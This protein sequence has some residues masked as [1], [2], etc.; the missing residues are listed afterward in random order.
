M[1]NTVKRGRGRPRKDSKDAAPV[2]VS[3]AGY[4]NVFLGMGNNKDRGSYTKFSTSRILSYPELD[5]MYVSEG[6]ARKVIDLPAEEMMRCGFEVE[7]ADDDESL[8]ALLEDIKAMPSVTDALKWSSLY[9]GALIVALLNDG[10]ELQDPLREESIKGIESL[11]VY[12]RWQ[13]S[14][15]QKYNDPADKRF[16]QTQ[17]WQISPASGMPYMVHE[18]RCIVVDGAQVPD[19]VREQNDGWGASRL[20]HCYDQLVRAGSS[21]Y[22]ANALLERSQ[23]AVHG[24]NGLTNILRSPGGENL[25]RQRVDI[26]DLSRSVSNTIVIDGEG[27]TYDVL[28]AT[29]TGV[30]DII[31]RL[32]HALCAVSGIPEQLLFGRQQS[33]IGNSGQ[34]SLESWYARIGQM[35]QNTLLPIIDRLITWAMYAQGRYTQDYLIE[36]KPLWVPSEKENAEVA[37]RK[38]K[39]AEMYVNM[40]A[41]D[42][43]EVRKGL[44]DQ[45]EI[46]DVD[47]L[48]EGAED[49]EGDDMEQEDNGGAVV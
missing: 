16:G 20:Q 12:D 18:S 21:H 14:R 44:E 19:R 6:F 37:E 7:G 31:D 22:W 40:G 27:E 11:R 3:D 45:Y 32:Q 39:T 10:G 42:P 35:Q 46:D 43:S 2:M 13:V 28:T 26:V 8:M 36:F 15:A 48:P 41:L 34:S 9:G 30:P 49:P 47:L 23:Q 25:V 5:N 38:A 4:S 29:L 33:G 17:L 1:E 24:I